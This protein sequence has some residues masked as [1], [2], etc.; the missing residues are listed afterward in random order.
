MN[1]LVNCTARIGLSFYVTNS[2]TSNYYSSTPWIG[3]PICVLDVFQCIVLKVSPLI[4]IHKK[5][6]TRIFPLAVRLHVSLHTVHCRWISLGKNEDSTSWM[7]SVWLVEGARFSSMRVYSFMC[8]TNVILTDSDLVN[9]EV[10]VD[11][12]LLYHNN[13]CKWWWPIWLK[14]GVS[15][16]VIREVLKNGIRT[17]EIQEWQFTVSVKKK[18]P[19]DSSVTHST[20]STPH[21]HLIR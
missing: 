5:S 2:F 13:L 17:Y 14:I 8:G 16:L 1:S 7:T 18:W 15:L 9:G 3:V 19:H 12:L 11:C 10:K 6:D 20:H 4:T 21:T